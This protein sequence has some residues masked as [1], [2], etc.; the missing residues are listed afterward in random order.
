[1]WMVILFASALTATPTT[2][3]A[4]VTSAAASFESFIDRKLLNFFPRPQLWRHT[5]NCS[6]SSFPH[7]YW[8][9]WGVGTFALLREILYVLRVFSANGDGMRRGRLKRD[10]RA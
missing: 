5:K 4:M 10:D 3:S 6:R 1:M 2:K 7:L 8:V 9:R